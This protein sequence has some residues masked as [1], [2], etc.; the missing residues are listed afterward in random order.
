[1]SQSMKI[2]KLSRLSIV[3]FAMIG[4][5]LTA[6]S[7]DDPEEVD[8]SPAIIVEQ[9]TPAV[10]PE[11]IPEITVLYGREEFVPWLE[12]ENWWGKAEEGGQLKVPHFI[13]TAIHPSWKEFSTTLPVPVK[14]ELF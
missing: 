11:P 8:K 10:A 4:T 9:S 5:L 7:Q 14:K 3:L 13:I 12:A 2:N 1:M 6:C